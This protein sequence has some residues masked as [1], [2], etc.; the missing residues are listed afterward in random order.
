MI[1]AYDCAPDT[2][3]WGPEVIYRFTAPASGTFRAELYDPSG[4]DVDIHLLRD[5]VIDGDIATGCIGR[6]HEKLEMSDLPAGEYFVVIDSWTDSSGTVFAG[7][8]SLAFEWIADDVWSEVPVAPGVTWSRLRSSWLHGG[9][10]TVN[11]VEVE[12]G[13]GWDIQPADHGGCST[14]RSKADALGAVA[15]VNGG[16]F[17]GGSCS[18]LDLLKSDGVLHSTNEMTGFEQRSMGWNAP[19]DFSFAW[20]EAGED[21][22][23]KNNAVGGFPSLVTDG[24]G[25]AE[26]RPGETV[27]SSG[28][29]S[30]NPRTAVG[31]GADGEVMLA[32]VDGRTSAGDGMTTQALAELMEDMGAIQALGLDGG[33]STTM[34]V[35]GCWLNDVVNNPS[36]DG[37][38]GHA[39]SRSVGSGLYIR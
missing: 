19:T 10:Q 13:F 36:D 6:A 30:R 34:V 33:G 7:D 17:S 29:W 20:I 11:L 24:V 9:D 28:D 5:P 31:V 32:T 22:V 2:R 3:E 38:A 16:F 1:G 4:V 37:S 14:V 27:Y 26:A 21:W 15:G 18:P 35:D 23:V 12:P 25:L 8:Y 39:G